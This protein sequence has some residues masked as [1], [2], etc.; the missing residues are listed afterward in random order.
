MRITQEDIERRVAAMTD[1]QKDHF[2]MLVYSLLQC[3]AEDKHAA[4]IVL[5]DLSDETASVVTVNCNEMDAST[6]LLA[7][8]NFFNYIN[9]REAPPK[10]AMN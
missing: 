6:L 4:V 3:Y 7:A 5:G 9:M 1:A 10:E 8:D 2:K